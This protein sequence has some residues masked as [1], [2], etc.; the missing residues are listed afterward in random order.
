[1]TYSVQQH[2]HAMSAHSSIAAV[3]DGANCY[4]FYT[5]DDNSVQRMRIA[6]DGTHKM[7]TAVALDMAPIPASPLSA[8]MFSTAPSETIV[9]FY[10]LHWAADTKSTERIRVYASTLTRS[11][12]AEV[13]A[14]NWAVSAQV[15]LAR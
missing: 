10:L 15:R 6:A 9:L 13:D 14:D 3:D 1:M 5:A 7:P 8:V 4:V 2:T 12:T 11:S